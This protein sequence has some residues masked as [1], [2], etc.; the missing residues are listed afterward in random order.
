[1]RNG[2][3]FAPASPKCDFPSLQESKALSLQWECEIHSSLKALETKR[4]ECAVRSLFT[5]AE[6]SGE[7][8]A[9]QENKRNGSLTI[10]MAAKIQFNRGEMD[11]EEIERSRGL[12]RRSL[13]GFEAIKI[14]QQLLHASVAEAWIPGPPE[15][16]SW[17]TTH[18]SDSSSTFFSVC[19]SESLTHIPS[20]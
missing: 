9:V 14:P 15:T 1:M 3:R 7:K 12:K 2:W 17:E 5:L 4:S 20:L 11:G 6:L 16:E 8:R 10:G 19:M 18:Q 13:R